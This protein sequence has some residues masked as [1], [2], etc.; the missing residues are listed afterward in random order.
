M[1]GVTFRS[2]NV[3][4][5]R[6][7]SF[8][9]AKDAAFK[10]VAYILPHLPNVGLERDLA[11]FKEYF[12]HP[13]VRNDGLKI[14]RRCGC[15]TNLSRRRRGSTYPW[16]MGL[17]LRLLSSRYAPTDH[18]SMPLPENL[19]GGRLSSRPELASSYTYEILLRLPSTL[20]TTTRDT[21][22]SGGDPGAEPKLLIE[23]R[24]R[25]ITHSAARKN[26]RVNPRLCGAGRSV[27]VLVF[28]AGGQ[29][30][31]QEPRWVKGMVLR[32]SHRTS[33][34]RCDKDYLWRAH[35]DRNGAQDVILFTT[36]KE[37]VPSAVD[38]AINNPIPRAKLGVSNWHPKRRG[39]H[40]WAPR[41]HTG[42]VS[43]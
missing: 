38:G 22:T 21:E 6:S 30:A 9:L 5:L 36:D 31:E 39:M 25:D 29:D 14:Y 17:S 20:I 33:E 18:T 19:Q 26:I 24:L 10:V 1:V 4:V 7:E 11:Q 41:W 27:R 43:L 35:P 2:L 15:D 13:A 3:L 16:S 23:R 8:H 12:T 40:Q 42:T 28:G 32:G 34:I 37:I